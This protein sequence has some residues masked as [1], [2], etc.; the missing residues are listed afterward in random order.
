MICYKCGCTLSEKNFCT[1]CGADVGMYKK[2]LYMSNK[3]Y[4]DALEKC[5]V[6]DLSGAIALLNQSIKFNRNNVDARNL[7][8][9]VYYEIGEVTDA[10][11]QWVISKNIRENKNIATGY[12][13]EIQNDQVGMEKMNQNLKK[14]NQALGL[15]YS[16]SKDYAKV[17]LKSIL[18]GGLKYL[19]A[20]QLL[21]LICIA[22]EDWELAQREVDRCLEIDAGNTLA[23][24]FKKEI[25]NAMMP[26]EE[27]RSRNKRV[28]EDDKQ[29]MRYQSGNE[30]I[31][32]PVNKKENRAGGTLL[33][34][35]IGLLIGIAITYF[36]VLPSRIYAANEAANEKI[37]VISSEKDKKTS[38]LDALSVEMTKLKSDYAN[39]Q[40]QLNYGDGDG[41]V[42]I[43]DDA[44]MN[45]AGAYISNPN[46]LE[47]I[48][49][50]LE[51][52]EAQDGVEGVI[53]TDAFNALYNEL[54]GEISIELASFYYN[55]GYEYYKSEDYEN[56]AADLRRAYDYDSSNGEALLYLANS[57]RR[58]G[59][60]DE[61]ADVYSS[62]IDLY[63]GTDRA[64]RAE[65]FLTEISNHE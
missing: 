32:M 12:L 40:N 56:A 2:I 63:P 53:R 59:R 9:L 25:E 42:S 26:L 45:A 14:F 60:E 24:R 35:A 28:K 30:T 6:R 52:L 44:L 51:Q 61:A 15:C 10:L 48:G 58:I 8:G 17:Q 50:Y 29:I 64:A 62:I 20:H 19:R 47:T 11:A 13:E 38:E 27:N 1:G 54:M 55:R 65:E 49:G 7:L 4:N 41:M 33:N 23:Q 34:I 21:A 37:S 39:L 57:L 5:Y 46:D 16:D 43:A 3:C 36:L 18:Q 31:I 22:G